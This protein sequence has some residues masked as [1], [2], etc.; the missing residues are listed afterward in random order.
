MRACHG[1]RI[2]RPSTVIPSDFE[3]VAEKHPRLR[4]CLAQFG[5]P[6]V[7]E[8]AMLCQVRK[9]LRRYGALYFDCAKGVLCADLTG[10]FPHL[11]LTAVCHQ[12]MFAS[13]NPSF[14]QIRMAQA[15]GELGLRDKHAGSDPRAERPSIFSGGWT[16]RTS[17][18][19]N[20]HLSSPLPF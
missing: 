5:W 12:V 10:T 18:K 3:R 13:S 16:D 4:I 1:N 7:R 20:A 19:E 2:P 15:I 17:G 6:W 11:G 9:R 8:T 14:E